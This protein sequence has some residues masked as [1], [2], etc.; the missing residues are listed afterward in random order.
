MSR[1]VTMPQPRRNSSQA[2]NETRNQKG[3]C[4]FFVQWFAA[5]SP[6]LENAA[7]RGVKPNY[8]G[9]CHGGW[10]E[11]RRRTYHGDN[12]LLDGGRKGDQLEVEG[13]VELP[14]CG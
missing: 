3:S 14:A 7:N 5:V 10:G 4:C 11:R 1:K 9:G 8:L 6:R 12:V 2:P 13:E